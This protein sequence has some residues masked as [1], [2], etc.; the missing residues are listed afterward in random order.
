MS[1][2]SLYLFH[3]GY[4]GITGFVA[5]A[6]VAVGIWLRTYTKR[7]RIRP[8]RTGDQQDDAYI[9]LLIAVSWRQR[10]RTFDTRELDPESS[11]PRLTFDPYRPPKWHKVEAELQAFGSESVRAAYQAG[12]SAHLAAMGTF[13]DWTRDQG[14]NNRNAA[15]Q[16]RRAADD[17]DRALVKCIRLELQGKGSRFAAWQ[18]GVAGD[19]A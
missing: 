4:P 19:G 2:P 18:P 10:K 11:V 13:A 15:L 16:A 12:S 8:V 5:V 14:E 1:S 17:A 6:L 9:A 7:K 3:G